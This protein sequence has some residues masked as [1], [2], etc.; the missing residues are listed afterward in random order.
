MLLHDLGYSA[1][2]LKRAGSRRLLPNHYQ[3]FY[4][5]VLDEPGKMVRDY[6]AL[7]FTEPKSEKYALTAAIA[8]VHLRASEFSGLLYPAVS[9]AAN[10]DNLALRPE[11]VHKG[12][13]LDKAQLVKIDEVS[14][15]GAFGGVVLCDLSGAEADGALHWTFR[16]KGVPIPPGSTRAIRPGDQLRSQSPGEIQIEGKRYRIGVGYLIEVTK[17]GEVIIRDLRGDLVK[18][19]P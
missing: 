6:L 5:S 18:P 13:K 8:E 17:S 1:Q 7:A 2:V 15:D 11:F 14:K 10:V 19:E 4:Q 12:L 16:E 3:S 9:K